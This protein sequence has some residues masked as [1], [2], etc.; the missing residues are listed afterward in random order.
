MIKLRK[1]LIFSVILFFAATLNLAAHPKNIVVP[2]G[3]GYGVI[4][5]Y[6]GYVFPYYSPGY[7]YYFP[8]YYPGYNPYYVGGN[9]PYNTT[10]GTPVWN[11]TN[12][13][14]GSPYGYYG[15]V[16]VQSLNLRSSPHVGRNIIGGLDYGERVCIMG[17][18]GNWYLVQSYAFPQKRGYAHGKY[19]QV[20][21]PGGPYYPASGYWPYYWFP[22]YRVR[23]W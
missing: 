19:F 11:G 1:A 21:G 2:T 8:Y 17:R 12:W 9:H 5:P 20:Q 10:V 13:Y 16:A 23:S 18:Y 14:Y 3:Y 15:A 6:G 7:A 4:S 22:Q